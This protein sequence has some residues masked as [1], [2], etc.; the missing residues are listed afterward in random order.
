MALF[1]EWLDHLNRLMKKKE[2][3]NITFRRQCSFTFQDIRQSN[4]TVKYLPANTT[5]ILQ[6]LDQGITRAFKERYRKHMLRS[7]L[8]QMETSANSTELCKS[9]SVFDA[10]DWIDRAWCETSN[11]TIIKC[12]RDPGFPVDNSEV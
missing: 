11:S 4:V 10:I 12:F 3:K 6:P 8:T 5:S 7:L 2:E 1:K 9:V